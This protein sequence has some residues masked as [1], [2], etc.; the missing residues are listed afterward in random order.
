M[1]EE[2][3]RLDSLPGLF[4]LVADIVHILIY[5]WTLY[6]IIALSL[7][8]FR[9]IIPAK[10]MRRFF[11][12]EKAASLLTPGRGGLS[13]YARTIIAPQFSNSPLHPPRSCAEVSRHLSVDLRGNVE[14]LHPRCPRDASEITPRCPLHHVQKVLIFRH[15]RVYEIYPFGRNTMGGVHPYWV[16]NHS[17]LGTYR[18]YKVCADG[19]IG[20]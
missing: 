2:P 14:P 5:H 1:Q 10:N 6:S 3:R 20:Y 11:F 17:L 8:R 4:C 9:C 15:M 12:L 16:F 13:R 7:S 18:K 19:I